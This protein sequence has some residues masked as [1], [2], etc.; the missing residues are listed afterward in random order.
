MTALPPDIEAIC[1]MLDGQINAGVWVLKVT[2][3]QHQ[4]LREYIQARDERILGCTNA[5]NPNLK[6]RN[7]R[8]EYEPESEYCI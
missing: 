6:Y 3:Q 4:A 2:A 1:K 5:S 8:I 7:H